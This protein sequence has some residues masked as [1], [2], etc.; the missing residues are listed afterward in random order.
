MRER[1]INILLMDDDTILMTVGE[2]LTRRG[3]HTMETA[4]AALRGRAYDY[5]RKPVQIE[6]LQACI[7]RVERD[8]DRKR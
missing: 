3:H 2:F 1:P 4:V 7:E 8:D 5:L 6:E